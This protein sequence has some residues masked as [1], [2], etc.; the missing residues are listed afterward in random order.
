M[1]STSNPHGSMRTIYTDRITYFLDLVDAGI[2][3]PIEYIIRVDGSGNLIP[4]V[5]DDIPVIWTDIYTYMNS[6]PDLTIEQLDDISNKTNLIQSELVRIYIDLNRE[7]FINKTY[8]RQL[9]D[10]IDQQSALNI[11]V[12]DRKIDP[13]KEDYELTAN[14]EYRVYSKYPL[15][16]ETLE[17]LDISP[18]LSESTIVSENLTYPFQT[19]MSPIELFDHCT[20]SIYVPYICINNGGELFYKIF[21]NPGLGLTKEYYANIIERSRKIDTNGTIMLLVWRKGEDFKNPTK[22]SL[23]QVFIQGGNNVHIRFDNKGQITDIIDEIQ[24]SML[25][26][27]PTKIVGSSNFSYR[28]T[29]AKYNKYIFQIQLTTSPILRSF[30]IMNESNTAGSSKRSQMYQFINMGI[31][32]PLRGETPSMSIR[33]DESG[34]VVVTLS[35]VKDK[36]LEYYKSLSSKLIATAIMDSK[37]ITS[38]FGTFSWIGGETKKI[39]ESKS[40]H[41]SG[42]LGELKRIAG[43]IFVSLYSRKCQGDDQPT[44]INPEDVED[45]KK[46]TF[47]FKGKTHNRQV[48]PFPEDNPKVNLICTRDPNKPFPGYLINKL[49]NSK[50]FPYIPCCYKTDYFDKRTQTFKKK[51]REKTSKNDLI[52]NKILRSGKMGTLPYRVGELL[53]DIVPGSY[54]RL[55]TILGP[56][57]IIHSFV[58]AVDEGYRRAI[59]DGNKV[60]IDA[61][62]KQYIELFDRILNKQELGSGIVRQELY[63]YTDDQIK[64]YIN[65]EHYDYEY[66]Y[67]LFEEFIGNGFNLFAFAG[68]LTKDTTTGL[69]GDLIIPRYKLYHYRIHRPELPTIILFKTWG[70]EGDNLI[71]PQYELIV[72]EYDDEI[73]TVFGPDMTEGLLEYMNS[74]HNIKVLDL[75]IHIPSINYEKYFVEDG[76][77]IISQFIDTYGKLRAI[78]LEKNKK[79]IDI[80]T[81]PSQ[82]MKYPRFYDITRHSYE[83]V[84]SVLGNPNRIE[85]TNVWY[86]IDEYKNAFTVPIVLGHNNVQILESTVATIEVGSLIEED[87]KSGTLGSTDRLVKLSKISLVLLQIIEWLYN[88]YDTQFLELGNYE[89]DELDYRINAF[90]NDVIFYS[91]DNVD[92][93]YVY[94]IRKLPYQL[95]TNVS[96]EEAMNILKTYIPKAVLDGKLLIY[97]GEMASDIIYFLSRYLRYARQIQRDN[98]GKITSRYRTIYDFA[99]KSNSIIFSDMED[100][101]SWIK[102]ITNQE[103]KISIDDKLITWNPISE[104][105]ELLEYQGNVY[106]IQN[107]VDNSINNCYALELEWR[108]SK[109]NLG[110]IRDPKDITDVR[111]EVYHLEPDNKIVHVGILQDGQRDTIKVLEFTRSRFAAMLKIE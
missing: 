67:R 81:I 43:D 108:N 2:R 83:T 109:I 80:L 63:D 97:G 56:K 101:Q 79:R 17:S 106:I 34:D 16:I 59:V 92:T 94:D 70:A 66:I 25:I 40:T 75:G 42:P 57:S 41:L 72:S 58:F 95:P 55:G 14:G 28:I 22:D 7:E 13:W 45:Y 82:P 91:E 47:W 15:M 53:S 85:G 6:Y 88:R 105:P 44:L 93:L 110:Y 71:H 73:Q 27:L 8:A 90:L 29:G 64:G 9:L 48:M 49:D 111:V 1:Q 33:Q 52:T 3:I 89:E 76:Y 84:I 31:N 54:K 39:K 61:K 100:I 107:V 78:R 30:I 19:N 102:K 35:D 62:E 99:P 24:R 20:P 21:Y 32:L 50:E 26:N 96:I 86:N 18:Y 104:D 23:I 74:V 60:L 103:S 12:L 65:G 98:N 68:S 51:N 5:N 38:L 11:D 69:P 87:I 77:I 4:I 37:Y 46:Q 10:I 36:E